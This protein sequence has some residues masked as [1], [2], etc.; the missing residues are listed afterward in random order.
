MLLGQPK[1]GEFF[2]LWLWS[3]VVASCSNIKASTFECH[4]RTTCNKDWE[5]DEDITCS[6]TTTLEYLNS[7]VKE[8]F[9]M[10]VYDTFDE[11]MLH[12]DLCLMLFSEIYTRTE[13]SVKHTWKAW[14]T[15]KVDWEPNPS[16]PNIHHC[17]ITS[18]LS[19]DPRKE[20]DKTQHVLGLD[21]DYSLTTSDNHHDFT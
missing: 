6:D 3:I 16:F 8:S 11:L 2:W 13:K 5:N 10:N 17:S 12:H 21:S 20:R 7:K 9:I 1:E 18:L 14:K 19:F 4:S 15:K